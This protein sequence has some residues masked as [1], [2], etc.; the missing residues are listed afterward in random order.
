MSSMA[1]LKLSVLINEIKT[2][3]N[4]FVSRDLLVGVQCNSQ[5]DLKQ[6]KVCGKTMWKKGFYS[7]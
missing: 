1:H 6:I 4:S 3:V 2:L 7:K 5:L